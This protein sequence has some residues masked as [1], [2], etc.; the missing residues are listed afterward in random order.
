MFNINS[1][2][3][4]SKVE[5]SENRF[6]KYP[7]ARGEVEKIGVL[8]C[9]SDTSP[10]SLLMFCTGLTDGSLLLSIKIGQNRKIGQLDV[11]GTWAEGKIYIF[12]LYFRDVN[13]TRDFTLFVYHTLKTL[14]V[15]N[16]EDHVEEG[17]LYF[18]DVHLTSLLKLGWC[19]HCQFPARQ[20]FLYVTCTALLWSYKASPDTVHGDTT[21]P[22]QPYPDKG[23][24]IRLPFIIIFPKVLGSEPKSSGSHYDILF[25]RL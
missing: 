17:G 4:S 1:A 14:F 3:P 24:G 19:C 18:G 6:C 9:S 13:L 12:L 5:L 10:A 23:T 25:T 8:V 16:S 15:T 11:P 2:L 21:T 20:P 7:R 22:A